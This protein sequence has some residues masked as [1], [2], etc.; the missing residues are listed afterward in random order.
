[1]HRL[2][3]NSVQSECVAEL[4]KAGYRRNAPERGDDLIPPIDKDR[5]RACGSRSCKVKVQVISNVQEFVDVDAC[6]FG[7]SLES[8]NRG[9]WRSEVVRVERSNKEF[10][11]SRGMDAAVAVGER[12]QLKAPDQAGERWHDVGIGPHAEPLREKL[13]V[14]ALRQPRIFF[15]ISK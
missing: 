2:K 14:R 5:L 3:R 6:Q 8:F 13:F 15:R 9:L 4:H 10:V 7:S 12:D 1:M 11:Q